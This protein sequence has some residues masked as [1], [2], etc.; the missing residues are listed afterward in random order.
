MTNINKIGNQTGISIPLKRQ[1]HKEHKIW[2][3]PL[4]GGQSFW[5]FTFLP[6]RSFFGVFIL[7]DLGRID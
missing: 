6:A 3:D 2:Q 7:T 1:Y 5:N 4:A